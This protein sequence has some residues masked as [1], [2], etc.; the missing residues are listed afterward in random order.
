MSTGAGSDVSAS[1]QVSLLEYLHACPVC[2]H[3]Q[4]DPYCRVP[5][6][7]N[8]GEYVRYDRCKGCGV[9]FRNPRIP[10]AAREA[11]YE[12]KNLSEATGNSDSKSQTHYGYMIRLL[13]RLAPAGSGRRLLDFGCGAGQ[14]LL[15]ARKSGFDVMGLELNKGLARFVAEEYGIPV[16]QGVVNDPEFASQRFDVIISSQVFEHLVDPR[17]TLDNLLG[18]LEKPGLMLIE[19]P[20]LRHIRE[21]LRR[22]ATMDD[23]HLFYFSSRS[24]GAMMSNAGLRVIEIQE[25]LRP[26]R[27]LR[28]NPRAIP[29]SLHEIGMKILSACQIRTGLSI[30]AVYE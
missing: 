11:I 16:H 5:S 18:H 22:G 27:V 10:A 2:L 19:V 24:L 13:S 3:E 9:V 20:N 26:Y 4:L 7:F 23:S 8:K 14:F 30:V 15:E 29:D 1:A 17:G 25:G 21:R 28:R 12:E 6:L